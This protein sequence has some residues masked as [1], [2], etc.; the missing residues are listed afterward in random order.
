M[1][2]MFGLVV[3]FFG[4]ALVLVS[5]GDSG[6]RIEEGHYFPADDSGYAFPYFAFKMKEDL[7]QS[8]QITPL[9]ELSKGESHDPYDGGPIGTAAIATSDATNADRVISGEAS[10]VSADQIQMDVYRGTVGTTAREKIQSYLMNKVSKE[11]ALQ[12]IREMAGPQRRGVRYSQDA[13]EICQDLFEL[14]C[15]QIAPSN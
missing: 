8:Y 9:G 12:R 5:C 6:P 7:A 11:E 3:G 15:E 2:K 14:T 13:E 1:N 10:V 4:L